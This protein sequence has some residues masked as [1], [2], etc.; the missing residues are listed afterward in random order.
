MIED[1]SWLR[2]RLLGSCDISGREGK[3]NFE[4]NKACA[5]FVYLVM[6]PGP[7]Q[8]DKLID[9][10]WGEFPEANARRNLR[11]A[12]WNLRKQI[13]R[14]DSSPA[15]LTDS[16]TVAYAPEDNIRVDVVEFHDAVNRYLDINDFSVLSELSAA[17]ELYQGDFLE[18]FH[19]RNAAVFD[20]WALVER[21]RLRT[22][23]L[24]AIQWLTI[25]FASL[26]ESQK[27][28]VFARRWVSMSPWQEEAH[29]QLMRLLVTS[30]QRDAAL[31]Q[32]ETCRQTLATELGVAPDQD[33]IQLFERIKSSGTSTTFSDSTFH[34]ETPSLPLPATPF[35][36]REDEI[37]EVFGILDNPACRLLT[38]TGPGGIGKTRLALQ[39]ASQIKVLSGKEAAFVPLVDLSTP[40]DI[41]RAVVSA[42]GF[43][44]FG[45]QKPIE[46][47]CDFLR[48]KQLVLVLDN[49][50]HLIEGSSLIREIL[51]V[52]PSV[53]ILVTSRERLNLQGEWIYNLEGLREAQASQ[54]F[55]QTAR[56]LSMSI[57]FEGEEANIFQ[58]CR[59]AY[60]VPLAIELAASWVRM[61]TCHE[62]IE[63]LE[64]QQATTVLASNLRDVPDR[65]KSLLAVFE[66]SWDQLRE[67]EKQILMNLSVFRGG[68]HREAANSLAGATLTD[69]SVLVDKSLL[70]RRLNSRYELHGLIR[71]F[72]A[73]KLLL[74]GDENEIRKKHAQYYSHLLDT[75]D[76]SLQGLLTLI[77]H[78]F[79]NIR[80]AWMWAVANNE[81][82]VIEK[83]HSEIYMYFEVQ[84][85]FLE[86][87][88]LFRETIK[89]LTGENEPQ[90]IH[91]DVDD[92]LLWKLL[93]VWSALTCRLGKL[94]VAS[95][96]FSRCVEIFRHHGAKKELAF[97]LFYLGDTT[98]LLGDLHQAQVCLRESLE[99]Y[100]EIGKQSD[101]AFS[102]NVLGLITA[103][104]GDHAKA[105]SLLEESRA[106]FQDI[107][108]PW[109]LTIT[110]INL[111]SLLKT[112]QN[113]PLATSILQESLLLCKQLGHR[114]AAA[115]CLGHLGELAQLQGDLRSAQGHYQKSLV[116]Y[117]AIGFSPGYLN[118]INRLAALLQEQGDFKR[119]LAVLLSANREYAKEELGGIQE[120]IAALKDKLLA[121]D[122]QEASEISL[123][124]SIEEIMEEK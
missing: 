101:I 19:V 114:W 84:S 95:D 66:H 39:I 25:S 32:F 20:E 6:N 2:L 69:L 58:I 120:K 71:M 16:Q 117:K 124:N 21:E 38:L 42:L 88:A 67:S 96:T 7:N 94:D 108:H 10:F 83:L 5:L 49:F 70:Y 79:E 109:G 111:G 116:L 8:R 56:R 17:T 93:A 12:L 55:V 105:Q 62:I 118:V 119:A 81:I 44:L 31:M 80:A 51:D 34:I 18:G 98:R 22:L 86:G 15:L 4:S 24:T 112:L 43:T 40:Q 54:L 100:K 37:S 123:T 75:H 106:I 9:L 48:E 36:G 121:N 65:H 47:L 99:L 13:H 64:S 92:L 11:H 53:K 113:Y 74:C 89:V 78:E 1:S 61:L 41:P 27:A 87:E 60:G 73:D 82:H 68:F 57:D 63:T 45:P 23:A 50:E 91:Q 85:A 110:N 3:I 72:A 104:Q 35:I 97:S 14:P 102:L 46:Q 30:G 107:D 59:L 26:D 33:T 28:L 103:A 52:A 115:V 77:G 122:Y 90:N 76:E 29:R